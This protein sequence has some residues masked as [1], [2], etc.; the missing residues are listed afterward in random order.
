MDPNI[1]INTLLDIIFNIR[2]P[3]PQSVILLATYR[4]G[5]M[6]VVLTEHNLHQMARD[7]ILFAFHDRISTEFLDPLILERGIQTPPGLSSSLLCQYIGNNWDN[8]NYLSFIYLSLDLG[9]AES[10]Y[11]HQAILPALGL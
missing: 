4:L 10:V 11:F 9:G 6:S 8:I 1:A 3:T 5:S 7:Q 2:P